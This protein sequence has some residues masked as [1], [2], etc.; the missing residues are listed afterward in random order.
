MLCLFQS[1][2]P[3]LVFEIRTLKRL[4][5]STHS[6]PPRWRILPP[7][8]I[9][10]IVQILKH[11]TATLRSCSLAAREFSQAALSCIGR[12]ITVNRVPC[13]K[14]CVQLLTANSAFHH[15]R[16]LDLGVT[17]KGSNS[18]E[19]LNEQ[20]A[21]LEIFAQRQTLTRLWLSRM[22]FSSIEPSQREKVRDIIAALSCTVNDLGLYECRFLSYTDMISFIRAFHYCDSLYIRDCATA[23]ENPIGD[24]F[25]G[26][27]RHNLSLITL[28]L[29]S[30]SPNR[31]TVDVSSLIE[32]AALDV[33]QLSALTCN[34]GKIGSTKKSRSVATVTSASPIRHFQLT[35]TEPGVFQGV[36]E[37]YTS[38]AFF[39]LRCS[40]SHSSI[41]QPNGKQVV[42]G[43]LGHRTANL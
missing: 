17:S 20:F 2:F 7:D 13:I 21:I 22:P 36:F 35:S 40:T 14:L 39:P 9:H 1:V 12:H 6:T 8:I 10:I 42:L 37:N 32:D 5:R 28:E 41:P 15:V 3:A 27:S 18:E 31:M 11:D 4:P 23:D 16:S 33:S 29:T 43:D 19:Y 26:L 30:A 38:T 34:I 25:S 24:T